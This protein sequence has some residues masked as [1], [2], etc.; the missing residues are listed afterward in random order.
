ME[1]KIGNG[2][3]KEA[4]T[5]VEREV[6]ERILLAMRKAFGKNSH[7]TILKGRKGDTRA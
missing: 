1:T 5:G 4:K 3:E 2:R 7:L 6:F